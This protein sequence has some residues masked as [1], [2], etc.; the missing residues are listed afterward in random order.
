MKAIIISYTLDKSNINQR[1]SIHR[2]LYGYKD[3]SNKGAYKYNRKGL[4]EQGHFLK[5]NRGVIIM[6]E[7]DKKEVLSVLKKNKAT[8]KTIPINANLS[9]FK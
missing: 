3:H 5:L 1:T 2:I 4:I 8:I 9:L 7:K 6:P